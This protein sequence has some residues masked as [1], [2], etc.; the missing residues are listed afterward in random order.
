[1]AETAHE[2]GI[3][4]RGD[5]AGAMFGWH[6]VDGPVDDFAAAAT[7]DS[8]LFARFHRASLDRGVFLAPSPFEASFMSVAHT[9]ELVDDTA[10]RLRDALREAVQ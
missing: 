6:F 2:L 4:F 3:P 9:Q 7:A 8:A 5:A 1:M 10:G